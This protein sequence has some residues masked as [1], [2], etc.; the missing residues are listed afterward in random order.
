MRLSL[1][2]GVNLREPS[3]LSTWGPRRLCSK[4][5]RSR[6]CRGRR[7]GHMHTRILQEPERS[8]RCLSAVSGVGAASPKAPGPGPAS[9]PQGANTGA[10]E[11]TAKRRTPEVRS[12]QRRDVGALRT[13]VA[14]GELDSR[15]PC[16]GKG[17]PSHGLVGGQ[18]GGCTE[19]RAPVTETPTDR[20]AGDALLARGRP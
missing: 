13:T 15:E 1:E 5:W 7:T 17:V 8:R 16:V 12:D 14:A 20:R 3:W 9:G 18:H 4:S 11:G 2:R 10:R 6:S 19:T